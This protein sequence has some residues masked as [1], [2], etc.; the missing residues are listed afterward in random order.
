MKILRQLLATFIAGG[1]LA[2]I[3][4]ALFHLYLRL[5]G[6]GSP[7][8]SLAA[9][10]SMGAIG[11]GL[12]ALGQYQK[13]ETLAGFG[14]FLPFS[15]FAAAISG[16]FAARRTAGASAG[17]ALGASGKLVA[18]VVGLGSLFSIVVGIVASFMK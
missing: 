3:G 8:V 4:Q 10:A 5:L 18:Y 7:F 9:L 14:A 11:A 6:E 15:G 1:V 16:A 13:L 2:L 17:E 12:F